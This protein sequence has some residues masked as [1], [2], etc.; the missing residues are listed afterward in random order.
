VLLY[1]FTGVAN[2]TLVYARIFISFTGLILALVAA[3]AADG[4]SR[5]NA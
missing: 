3:R 2:D 1:Y 4:T 5:P